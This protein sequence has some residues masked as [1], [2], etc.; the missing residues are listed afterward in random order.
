MKKVSHS[1][2]IEEE[3]EQHIAAVSGPRRRMRKAM[4]VSKVKSD[5][6]GGL[7]NID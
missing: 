4:A 3:L 1:L 2:S 6:V 7:H 5:G